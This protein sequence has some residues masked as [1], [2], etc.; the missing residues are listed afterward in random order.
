MKIVSS[1]SEKFAKKM[2]DAFIIRFLLL[3]KWALCPPVLSIVSI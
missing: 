1:K 3:I 2:L